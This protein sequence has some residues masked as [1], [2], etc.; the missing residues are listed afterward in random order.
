MSGVVDVTF[1]MDISSMLHAFTDGLGS[2][3]T[4]YDA[5]ADLNGDNILFSSAALAG[6]PDFPAAT[7]LFSQTLSATVPL[8][9]AL[10]YSLIVTAHVDTFGSNNVPEPGTLV[11]ALVALGLL[12]ICSPTRGRQPRKRSQP[13]PCA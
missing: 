12:P 3:D 11:L 7:Q 9:S 5:A 2:F 1:S 13:S 8:D 10:S 4:D 6:G